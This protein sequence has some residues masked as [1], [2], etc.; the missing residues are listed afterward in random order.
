MR[1]NLQEFNQA[2][3]FKDEGYLAMVNGSKAT[4]VTFNDQ[5][6]QSFRPSQFSL[7]AS[8]EKLQTTKA[9]VTERKTHSPCKYAGLNYFDG[10]YR[11]REDRQHEWTEHKQTQQEYNQLQDMFE[12]RARETSARKIY[13][14]NGSLNSLKQK[15]TNN[16]RILQQVVSKYTLDRGQIPFKQLI[17]NKNNVRV[18]QARQLKAEKEN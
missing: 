15:K 4:S 8:P 2:T 9:P 14:K 7:G 16:A 12:T 6:Q 17:Q 18:E 5:Q 3:A 1:Q 13:K 10:I 11:I